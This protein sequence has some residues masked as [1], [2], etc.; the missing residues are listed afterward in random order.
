MMYIIVL[1]FPT[2]AY[3]RND[4]GFHIIPALRGGGDLE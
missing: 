1:H 4:M 2:L 3:P